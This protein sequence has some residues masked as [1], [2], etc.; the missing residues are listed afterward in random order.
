MRAAVLWTGGKDSALAFY[1]ASLAGYEIANLL[2]FVPERAD[3]LAHPLSFMKCQARAIDISHHEAV[4]GGRAEDGYEKAIRSFGEKYR[5]DALITG[6]IAEVDGYSNW[7][8][9]RCANS[10]IE[11][12]MPL[13][14][15]DRRLIFKELLSGG[16]K[17]VISCINK[18]R[19]TEEWLGKELDGEALNGLC[20]IRDKTGLDICGE[21][22]EYHTLVFDGPIFKKSIVIGSYSKHASGSLMYIRP[23]DTALKEKILT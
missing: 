3:F 16:F 7:I 21:D 22:G 14:G 15:M 1:K 12:I 2:T 11:V 17:A 18:E 19:L 23:R 5:I 4:I 20:G 13:W 8:R 9:E 6:D 10:G